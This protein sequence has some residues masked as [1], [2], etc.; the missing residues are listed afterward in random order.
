MQGKKLAQGIESAPQLWSS[1][2]FD[3]RKSTG[4]SVY[5]TAAAEEQ[6][7]GLFYMKQWLE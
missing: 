5:L 4:K 6:V 7:I 2:L 1:C 3:P